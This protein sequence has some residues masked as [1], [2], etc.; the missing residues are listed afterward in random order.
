MRFRADEAFSRSLER[1]KARDEVSPDETGGSGNEDH[2]AATAWSVLCA[3]RAAESSKSVERLL[4]DTTESYAREG[5]LDDEC[6][7][8]AR[9]SLQNATFKAY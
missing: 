6:L 3:I 4:R 5:L 7:G 2:A 9:F 1:A 8:D